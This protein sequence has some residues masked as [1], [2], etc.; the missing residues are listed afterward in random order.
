[1]N[2]FWENEIVKIA[3]NFSVAVLCMVVFLAIFELVTKYKNW[4]EIKNGNVAVAMATGGKIF[5]IANIFR[6]AINHHESLLSVIGWGV[7]GFIL[8]LVAYFIYEFLTPKFN[9]DEEISKDN[10]AVGLISMIISIG[11]S[12]VIGESIR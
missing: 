11:L 3:A 5:G 9:I 12:F 10:R 7:Y 2:S 4:D 8:L 1:M 6:Y